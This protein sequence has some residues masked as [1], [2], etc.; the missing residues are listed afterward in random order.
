MTLYQQKYKKIY[1]KIQ[2]S[3]KNVLTLQKQYVIINEVTT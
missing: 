3:T 1:K 2:K